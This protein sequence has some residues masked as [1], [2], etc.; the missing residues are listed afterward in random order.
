MNPVAL[1][2]M[3]TN[4]KTAYETFKGD[5]WTLT[6][7]TIVDDLLYS[8]IMDLAS[9]TCLHSFV[10]RRL[11]SVLALFQK[12]DQAEIEKVIRDSD[13]MQ[14]HLTLQ[15]WKV[16]E[17][18][19]YR[20]HPSLLSDLLSDGWKRLTI[21]EEE[22]SPPNE[23]MD[24]HKIM[25]T[26]ILQLHT[27]YSIYNYSLP[28]TNLESWY[29]E[30]TWGFFCHFFPHGGALLYEP[31]EVSSSASS[32][33]KNEGR[34][35][36]GKEKQQQGRKADGIISCSNTKME[37]CSLEFGCDDHELTGTKELQDLRK[38]G[39][40]MKDMFD[41]ILLRCKNPSEARKDLRTFGLLISGL[42]INIFSLRYQ[43]GRFFRMQQE[44]S[45]S[46]P[47]VW[48]RKENSE[49]VAALLCKLLIFKYRLE[50]MCEKII[51]WI[52]STEVEDMMHLSSN[53]F[54]QDLYII[55]TL[56]TPVGSPKQ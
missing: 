25:F 7:G 33:R 48:T 35:Y 19:H 52:N 10:I 41:A 40:V 32:R 9:E 29:R 2:Q 15:S 47:S 30:Y 24:F 8:Y 22:R 38:L 20:I 4:F 18:S 6:S 49:A 14:N 21:Q 45:F 16:Q 13:N 5:S 3:R 11:E 39:K 27:S 31:G 43:N 51:A 55:P 54:Q 23:L 46:L 42:K 56:P 36:L 17:M 28:S 50:E 44:C 26:S 53:I 1:L 12:S 37:I 34:E